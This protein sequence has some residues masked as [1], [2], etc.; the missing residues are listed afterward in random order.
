MNKLSENPKHLKHE[1]ND[2]QAHKLEIAL[3]TGQILLWIIIS[4]IVVLAVLVLKIGD[5]L[6]PLWMVDGREI[7]IAVILVIVIFLSF[8]SP[9]IIEATS[10]PRLLTG[11]GKMPGRK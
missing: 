6:W 4:L 11:P 3:R 1:Y 5:V 8:M 2:E 10:D 9:V 7:F